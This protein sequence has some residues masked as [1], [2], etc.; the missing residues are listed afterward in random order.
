M[1]G[2]YKIQ[3]GEVIRV[4]MTFDSFLKEADGWRKE[5]WRIMQRRSDVE[6]FLLTDPFK[7]ASSFSLLII[8]YFSTI[9][10]VC[11]FAE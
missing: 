10:T 8:F 1:H 2:S 7:T 6:F 3:S 11:S 9:S 5:A 4:C